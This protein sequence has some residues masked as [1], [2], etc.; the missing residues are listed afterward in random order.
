MNKTKLEKLY[1]QTWAEYPDSIHMLKGDG[2]DRCIYRIINQHRSIIGIIGKNRAE[3]EAFIHFSRHF[4]SFNLPVPTIYAEN[5]DENIYLEEDL[6][7][8]HF[9]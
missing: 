8:P 6:G 5:L 2:S 3:N 9:F 4:G 1:Y 7:S